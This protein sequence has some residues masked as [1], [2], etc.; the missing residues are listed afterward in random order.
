MS[1]VRVCDKCNKVLKCAPSVKISVDFH[2][3]CIIEYELC[4]ECKFKLVKW[5]KE[6]EGGL[7]RNYDQVGI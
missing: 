4:E 2:Y 5:M 6:K 3:D 7:K 1:Q